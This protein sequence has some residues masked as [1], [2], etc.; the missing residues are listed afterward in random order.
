M[1]LPAASPTEPGRLPAKRLNRLVKTA[2]ASRRT[3]FFA[4][5]FL[6]VLHA[7]GLPSAPA[8]ADFDAGVRAYDAGDY[9]A[10]FQTWLPLARDGDPFAQ[11]NLGHLYRL[12]RGVPQDFAVAANWY[13]RAS[14]QGLVRAQA[15]LANMY[16]RGQGVEQDTERA[17]AWFHRAAVAGHIISQFNV[18][19]LFDKGLGVP[20]DPAKAM[21]WFLAASEGGHEKARELL[22]TYRS[23]GMKPANPETLRDEPVLAEAINAP[24]GPVAAL[25]RASDA[26]D[27]DE[28][29][30]PRATTAARSP[31][32][33]RPA[34]APAG[35]A[36]PSARAPASANDDDDESDDPFASRAPATA[37][38]PRATAA[39][40]AR[41]AA[42]PPATA[43]SRTSAA[44]PP[45]GSDDDL[46]GENESAPASGVAS[47]PVS[48]EGRDT[49][50]ADDD[51]VPAPAA[52]AARAPGPVA[53]LPAPTAPATPAPAAVAVTPEQQ[54]AVDLGLEAYRGRD[55]AGAMRIWKPQAET[56]NREAQFYVGGLYMDGSGVPADVVQAH[57]WW[58]LASDKGHAKA[59]EFVELIESIMTPDERTRA[60]T[61][62]ADLRGTAAA[63]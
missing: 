18:G 55:Y 9:E 28:A 46:S 26:D 34:A 2:F 16:L 56:D 10:A 42:S 43:A 63:R 23:E 19:L 60:R 44:A 38:V 13:R 12:G 6:A 36:A 14:D 54:R 27:E 33:G 40:P 5:C 22:A 1:G 32:A 17:A 4:V 47:G 45:P 30:P 37:P 8:R 50:G 39:A 48:A 58:R 41:P 62:A 25:P 61:L 15:N 24:P 21:G 20:R 29:P 52:P 11:R 49:L 3:P 57:A 7:F 51:I 31:A 35:R 53:S 59:K